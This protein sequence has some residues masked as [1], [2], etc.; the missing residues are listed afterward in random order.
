L[1]RM[2]V[3]S[4]TFAESQTRDPQEGYREAQEEGGQVGYFTCLGFL[5]SCSATI[6][7]A[8]VSSYIMHVVSYAGS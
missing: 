2:N 4:L 7:F 3:R 8:I 5:E 6:G 1:S